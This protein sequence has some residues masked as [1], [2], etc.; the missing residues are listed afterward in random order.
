MLWITLHVC[1]IQDLCDYVDDIFG[2][3]YA[4]NLL[5]YEKYGKLMPAH[6][7]RLLRLWDELGIPHEEDK[8]LYGPSL[9]IIGFQVNV[10]EMSITMP[11]DAQSNLEVSLSRFVSGCRPARTLRQCQRLAGHINWALNVAPWL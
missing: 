7:V 1:D 5:F 10:V 3:D 9:L 4:D 6:Q 11:P 2:W 8:Q